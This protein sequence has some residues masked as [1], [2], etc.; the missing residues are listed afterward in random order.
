MENISQRQQI[1]LQKFI[2]HSTC[3]LQNGFAY[4]FNHPE[5]IPAMDREMKKIRDIEKHLCHVP[6]AKALHQRTLRQ[7][8]IDY[9]VKLTKFGILYAKQHPEA[10]NDI[11]HLQALFDEYEKLRIECR[12][13]RNFCVK[14][15]DKKAQNCR[16]YKGKP[17]EDQIWDETLKQINFLDQ[18]IADLQ[19]KFK[20]QEASKPRAK[21]S[22]TLKQFL[23]HLD[24]NQKFKPREA[25]KPSTK[26]SDTMKHFN[27]YLENM[28]A[29]IKAR[30]HL[31]RDKSRETK[32]GRKTFP[33]CC[34]DNQPEVIQRVI[35][36]CDS[37]Y[38]SSEVMLTIEE[39]SNSLPR[40][41]TVERHL[42]IPIET[43][44]K[45]KFTPRITLNKS[46]IDDNMQLDL[47]LKFDNG[48]ICQD[49]LVDNICI[50]NALPSQI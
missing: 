19:C 24:D 10:Y 35:N 1:F 7:T 48:I 40:V 21:K 36:L 46:S 5:L 12:Q 27:E 18:K 34:M 16:K 43:K 49:K 11:A 25:S 31:Q 6:E 37:D 2:K 3:M 30:K 17:Y 29:E 20:A 13:D 22:D 47:K 28:K 8:Y 41:G 14:P 38:D 9:I 45:L 23:K 4:L 44:N 50:A 32:K 39:F 26:A 33:E 42:V 15:E